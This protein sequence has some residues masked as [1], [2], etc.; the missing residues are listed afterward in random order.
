MKGLENFTDIFAMIV[1]MA[2]A[3]MKGVKKKLKL[4]S[5]CIGMIVAGILSFS[6]IGVIELFY[7]DLTPK[8]IILV[9]FVVGWLANEIT[10]KLDLVFDDIF[11]IF[12]N[13][14]KRKNTEK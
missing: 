11:D 7:M 9:S 5:I 8:L 13:W 1:G 3:L 10:E 4:Q 12:F 14:V 2:G 6:L